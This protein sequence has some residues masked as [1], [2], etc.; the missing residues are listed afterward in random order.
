MKTMDAQEADLCLIR[1]LRHKSGFLVM[2]LTHIMYIS[3]YISVR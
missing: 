3:M 1:S 2:R